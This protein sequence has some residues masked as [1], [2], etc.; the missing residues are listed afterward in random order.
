VFA[1]LSGLIVDQPGA[2]LD[3]GAG[4]GAL[5]RALA[6]GGLA[7][8]RRSREKLDLW[9]L[10]AVSSESSGDEIGGF[11]ELRSDL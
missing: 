2:V 8:P 4:Q 11:V 7:V 9:R 3:L 10:V 1:V 5:A 6:A